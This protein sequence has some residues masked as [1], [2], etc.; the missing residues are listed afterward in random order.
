MLLIP[1]LKTKVGASDLSFILSCLNVKPPSITYMKKEINKLSVSITKLNKS[2]MINN[3]KLVTEV[4]HLRKKDNSV[5]VETDTSYNNRPQAGFEAGTQAFCPLIEN[6]TSKK[7]II[8][9]ETA[10]KLCLKRSCNH[11]NCYKTY[12]TEESIASSESHLAKRN[13]DSINSKNILSIGSVI[14]DASSQLTKTIHE[15]STATGKTINHYN[16]V[17]HHLRNF[18]KHMKN[19]KLKSK[20]PGGNKKDYMQ[21]LSSS[22]RSRIRLELVRLGKLKLNEE[23]FM[24][25]AE[26][27]IENVIRCFGNNH[28][29]CRTK[30]LV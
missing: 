1:A 10:N 17:I 11:S 26:S 19:I 25:R 15:H 28:L 18:Q 24:K 3:Q 16:C 5:S 6:E 27:S 21:K 29:Y 4:N 22:F 30:S 23:S 20:V 8:N 9:I 13:F 7:L 12:K 14:C 2:S